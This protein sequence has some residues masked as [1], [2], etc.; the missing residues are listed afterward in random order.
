ML[1]KMS[2]TL[3][4]AELLRACD[5]IQYGRHL[6][7]YHNMTEK[8]KACN[9]RHVGCDIIK[10]FAAFCQHFVRFSSKTVKN[11]HLKRLDYLLLMTSYL[12][13]IATDSLSNMRQ[14]VCKGYAHS[15]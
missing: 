10:H 8:L 14:N 9:A 12:F 11:T 15:Y 4:V 2:Y 5:V 6:E 13:T 1:Y 7:F 3:W